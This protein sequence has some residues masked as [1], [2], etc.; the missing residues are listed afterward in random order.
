[1]NFAEHIE[2]MMRQTLGVDE[3]EAVDEEE[4]VILITIHIYLARDTFFTS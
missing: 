1:M 2:K 4:E 3:D